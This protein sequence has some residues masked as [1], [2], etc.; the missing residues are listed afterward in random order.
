MLSFYYEIEF[1]LDFRF[2]EYYEYIGEN[3]FI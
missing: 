2:Y 1:Y 3:A